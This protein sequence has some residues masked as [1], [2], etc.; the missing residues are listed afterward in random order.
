[1]R[2]KTNSNKKAFLLIASLFVF[3]SLAVSVSAETGFVSVWNTSKTSMGSSNATQITL[4]LE[5]SGVY[6]FNIDWGFFGG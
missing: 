3:I 5:S 2:N 6:N 1:M 4:P